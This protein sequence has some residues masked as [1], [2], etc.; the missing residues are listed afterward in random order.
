MYAQDTHT[1]IQN[2]SCRPFRPALVVAVM[3][4]D[5]DDD[6]E[7]E[8]LEEKLEKNRVAKEKAQKRLETGEDESSEE[9]EEE[10]EEKKEVPKAKKSTWEDSDEEEEERPKAAPKAQPQ[11]SD[12]D[13]GWEDLEDEDKIEEKLMAQ[14]KEKEKQRKRDAGED[15][16]SEGEKEVKKE[17]KPKPAPKKKGPTQKAEDEKPKVD[18][19]QVKLADPEAERAR[20]RKLEEERDARLGMDL[21][22]GFEKKESLLEKEKREKAEAAAAKKAAAKPKA[23]VIDEFD[24]LELKLSSDVDSLCAK[25]LNKFETSTLQKGGPQRFLSNL[26]KSLE[27]SFDTADLDSLE[28]SL[29]QLIKDKK[30]T[31]ANSTLTKDNKASTKINKN[32]K[33]N[34]QSEWEDVY[35]GG[36]DDEDWTQEEWDAW[37]AEQEK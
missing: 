33:F 28:K 36:D 9:E 3:G 4:W 21:F 32:T 7:N 2:T 12:D 14:Q 35:G 29:S 25:C 16:E 20:L 13:E 5:S 11:A 15:T 24:N 23:T 27:S 22:S 37:Y 34:K 17:E 10:E 31:K 26:I 19:D 30:A 6:W 18:P 8:N 1:H